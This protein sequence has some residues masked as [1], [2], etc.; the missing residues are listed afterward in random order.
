[1]RLM[2]RGGANFTFNSVHLHVHLNKTQG[3]RIIISVGFRTTH[4]IRKSNLCE[5]SH[6]A[7]EYAYRARNESPTALAFP[8]HANM[9]ERF[10]N[11]LQ[12]T[13]EVINE[14]S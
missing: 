14:S 3:W 2:R 8:V 7:I 12:R 11:S 4:R 1:M 9:Y 6:S 5:K 10:E 13:V